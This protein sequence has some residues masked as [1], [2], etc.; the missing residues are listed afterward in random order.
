MP[1]YENLSEENIRELHAVY[2]VDP[3]QALLEVM[4]RKMVFAVERN[5]RPL[6]I[7]GIDEEGCMW[8][9]FSKAMKKNWI[10]FCRASPDLIKFYHHFYDEI[11]CQV[12]TENEMIHQWLVHLGFEVDALIKADD[13]ELVQF[14]R[15]KN[16]KTNV[17]S[18]LS[19]PVMH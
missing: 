13:V 14:V 7:T 8:T 16:E 17:Y 3:L 18:L 11:T 1:F 4:S 15:C 2:N 9:L 12:W 5:G 19:R 6:A 10:R